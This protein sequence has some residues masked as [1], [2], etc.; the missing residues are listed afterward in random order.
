MADQPPLLGD[1]ELGPVAE[2]PRLADV[3]E[4]RRRHQ[5]VRVEARV[6]LADLA[7]E[8]ADR[9]GVLDQPADVG[10]MA[11]PG[12]GSATELGGDGLG[13]QHPLRPPRAAA[14][15]GPR[16]SGARETPPAPPRPGRR[17]A[18]T[19]EGSSSSASTGW[20]SS[21]SATSSPRKRSTLPETRI[22]SPR[23]NRPASRST[24]RKHAGRDRPAAVAQLQ[25]QV[26]RAVARGEPVLPHAGVDA[27]EALPR[28]QLGDLGRGVS[29]ASTPSSLQA[30]PDTRTPN[31]GAREGRLASL[32]RWTRSP[33]RPSLRSFDHRFWSALSP[34]GTM[35]RARPRQH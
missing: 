9:D 29:V 3:V 6:K 7:D 21:T 5:Q 15:R 20:M 35:R 18:G 17:R 27:A 23:S 28:A 1:P 25:R 4:Q 19:S 2:L 34:A 16:A 26:D 31:R 12:A 24:S 22:A 14:R 10:V 32:D 13:E 30:R 33:G 11:G 8:G